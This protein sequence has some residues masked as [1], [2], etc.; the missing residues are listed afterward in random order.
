MCVCACR[1]VTLVGEKERKLLKAVV[2]Q[3][4]NAVKLR[5][6]PPGQHYHRLLAMTS[7]VVRWELAAQF[8]SCEMPGPFATSVAGS[9]DRFVTCSLAVDVSKSDSKQPNTLFNAAIFSQP[10]PFEYAV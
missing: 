1:S 6:I 8:L 2:K 3:A 9:Q 7:L 5:V 10:L 4:K